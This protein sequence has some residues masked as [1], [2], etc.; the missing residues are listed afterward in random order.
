LKR[1]EIFGGQRALKRGRQGIG[2]PD[3]FEPF[4]RC[5]SFKRNCWKGRHKDSNGNQ[6]NFESPSFLIQ[7]LGDLSSVICD[8]L[9]RMA[10]RRFTDRLETDPT[11]ARNLKRLRA[12]SLVKRRDLFVPTHHPKWH[13]GSLLSAN[14]S[15]A[16]HTTGHL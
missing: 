15:K 2:R 6:D 1:R 4:F 9:R 10:V 8:A 5:R 11:L 16:W 3:S 7:P 13:R 14:H 12:M